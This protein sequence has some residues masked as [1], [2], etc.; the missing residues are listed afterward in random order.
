[1]IKNQKI[2]HY[3]LTI[4]FTLPLLMYAQ[5]EPS[6]YYDTLDHD[7][8]APYVDQVATAQSFIDSHPYLVSFLFYVPFFFNDAY[9]NNR[10]SDYAEMFR[11]VYLILAIANLS[12]KSLDFGTH[13][14]HDTFATKYPLISK[15]L[16]WA[17]IS[18]CTKL[19]IKDLFQK[20]TFSTLRALPKAAGSE[21]V[22]AWAKILILHI[23]SYVLQAPAILLSYA[24]SLL[25]KNSAPIKHS[26][27]NQE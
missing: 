24:A 27:D 13:F 2:K 25:I 14:L 3:L 20:P 19:N 22:E 8:L 12:L 9:N 15:S 5:H 16:L 21:I 17:I 6:T 4:I 23:P 26:A 10:L 18:V 11:D 1:M 7:M